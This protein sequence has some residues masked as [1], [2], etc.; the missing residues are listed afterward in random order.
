MRSLFFISFASI[1]RNFK[2]HVC[3]FK[4]SLNF[5]GAPA[6]APPT[7]TIRHTQFV[8]Q[9]RG[10]QWNKRME[11]IYTDG[12][13]SRKTKIHAQHSHGVINSTTSIVEGV[14]VNTNDLQSASMFGK[15][16]CVFTF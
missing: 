3:E 5:I 10:G 11:R 4:F 1:I 16:L 8:L 7:T 13:P 6:P 2:D 14:G 15:L 9:H 12:L